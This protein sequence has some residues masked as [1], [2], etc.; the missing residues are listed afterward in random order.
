MRLPVVMLTIMMVWG[1]SFPAMAQEAQA[2]AVGNS[3]VVE[4]KLPIEVHG[5]LLGIFTR[6]TTGEKPVKGNAGNYVL[7]EERLRLD[8]S[9]TSESGT[10]M[11]QVKGDIFHDSIDDKTDTDLR[12][13]YAGYT[14]GALDLRLGRQIVTWGVGDLFFINDVFPKDWESFFSG[15]PLEYLKLGVDSLRARYSSEPINAEFLLIPYF[16]PDNMPSDK[17]FFFFN[18]FSSVP[19]QREV[20]PKSSYS[21]TELALRLY[22]QAADFDLSL[23]AFR[24]FWHSP[25]MKVDNPASPAVATTFYPALTVYGI[26]AQRNISGGVLSLETG[27]YDSRDDRKGDDPTVPNSQW[28]ALIGYQYQLWE[29]F[30]AGVQAY[31]E[32]MEDYGA[33]RNSLPPDAPIQDRFRG[34]LSTR[35]TQ[36]LQYQTWKLTVFTAYS[37]TDGDYFIQPEVSYKIT[38][39]L[40][41][42]GGANIWDGAQETT[43]FGQFNKSDNVYVS[44]RFDF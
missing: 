14:H 3:T 7:G 28:R 8:L 29:D 10:A 37:P 40:S 30:T 26:S 11:F 42:S 24:G 13:A 41:V 43:F 2:P 20:E 36:F 5:F 22:R 23:Y 16:T 1:I 12:E 38:D 31:S 33:Y 39:N 35:L 34:V 32:Y 27:Y 21:N 18:P 9:E 6:R 25:A 4:G 19:D 15:R 44:A 17:R